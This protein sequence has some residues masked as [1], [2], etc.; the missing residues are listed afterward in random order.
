MV[1]EYQDTNEM[2]E[3]LVLKIAN[4]DEHIPMFMVGD[5]KQS[6][7]RFRQADPSIFQYKF[8]TFTKLEEMTEYDTNIRIDLKYNYRSEKVVLDSVNYIFDCIMDSSVGG[9][10]YIHGDNAILRYDFDAK[11][12]TLPELEKKS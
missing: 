11:G 7:Y 12:T 2:Q 4:Y 9:L 8:D 10:E 5:M 1:D 3:N 6:I